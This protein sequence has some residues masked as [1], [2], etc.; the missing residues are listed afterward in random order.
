MNTKPENNREE[1]TG[2]NYVTR[3]FASP[4]PAFVALAIAAALFPNPAVGQLKLESLNANG[5]LTWNDPGGTGTHYAV[6][7]TTAEL[8]NWYSWQD[9]Q[10][11][12]SGLGPTGSVYVPMF[13]RMVSPDP[14]YHSNAYYSYFE[15]LPAF[16]PITRRCAWPR[17]R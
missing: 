16:N 12:L 3:R 11:R 7:W 13:Y 2:R 5:R 10:A 9:A 6:Q 17:R 4:Y 1:V 14:T 15:G 8:T